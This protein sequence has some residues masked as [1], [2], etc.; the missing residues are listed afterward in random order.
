M[1]SM[2]TTLFA[3]AFLALSACGGG[4]VGPDADGLVGSW[5]LDEAS[6]PD[7]PGVT[8]SEVRVRYDAD[9][10]SDYAARMV[11]PG[12]DGGGTVALLLDGDVRW[13]L[14]ETVLTRT[15]EQMRVSAAAPSAATDEI[16]ALYAQGLNSS[17]PARFIV[18]A[19]TDTELVLLDPD[20]G[21]TLRFVRS[22]G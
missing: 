16:A 1:P 12:P 18:E 14:D 5:T 11:V 21:D 3:A 6:A 20:T 2:R 22:A 4:G 13:T 9:G 15:L 19:L 8:L 7:T 10:T 17:P